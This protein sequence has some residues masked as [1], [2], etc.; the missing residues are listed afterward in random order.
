MHVSVVHVESDEFGDIAFAD[1]TGLNL[2]PDQVNLVWGQLMRNDPLVASLTRWTRSVQKPRRRGGLL[3]RDR[4]MTPGSTFDQ[5]RTARSA[6]DDDVVDGVADLTEALAFKKVGFF[7]EDEDEENA[8]NQWAATVNLDGLLRSAW[9]TYYTD[10]HVVFAIWWG[11][12]SYK[13]DGRTRRGNSRRKVFDLAVPLAI[14]TW[15]TLK[16]TP[17]GDLLFGR[18]RLAYIATMG[19]AQAFDEI[20]GRQAQ[21][22]R[23]LPRP[24]PGLPRTLPVRWDDEPSLDDDVVNRLIVGRYHPDNDEAR[25]LMAEGVDPSHLYL[26]R[27]DSV[28]RHTA[29]KGGHERFARPRM[30]STFEVLD[31]KHQQRQKDRVFLLAGINFI[32]VIKQGSDLVP[33]LPEEISHLRANA[34]V[35]AQMPVIVGPHTLTVEIISPDQEYV[36]DK[37]KWDVLDDRLRARL[38]RQFGP[39]PGGSGDESDL[40]TLVGLWLESERHMLN[41]TFESKVFDLIR[42]RN[43]NELVHPPKLRF[44]PKRIALAF[45]AE[46]ASFLLD[47]RERNEVSRDTVHTEFGLTQADEAAMRTREERD[48]DDTFKTLA[49]P[50]A[51]PAGG[52][53]GNDGGAA[54]GQGRAGQKQAGRSGGGTSNGGGAAPGSGQGQAPRRLRKLSASAPRRELLAMAKELEVPGRSRMTKAELASAIADELGDDPTEDNDE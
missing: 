6:L 2:R 30:K 45:D 47:M 5:I 22:Q 52:G 40:A 53:G 26:L 41:R 35:I 28:F 1:A 27:S 9:R 18:E 54:G 14:D 48:F 44:Y 7:C 51:A 21:L 19:E 29:T 31:M 13:V 46:Y 4:F 34:Q 23:S 8:W 17:V 15:D 11:R 12:K 20:L 16:V 36:L 49:T 33:A 38:L 50:G 32:L 42:A 37:D 10:S 24:G 3:D 39:R 43:E 25:L